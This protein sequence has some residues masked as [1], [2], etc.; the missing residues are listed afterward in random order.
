MALTRQSNMCLRALATTHGPEA[1]VSHR[2]HGRPHQNL[3]ISVF[4][5][6]AGIGS[7][8]AIGIA[9][10]YGLRVDMDALD[11]H[12][13]DCLEKQQAVYAVVAIIG[14]TEESSLDPL[15]PIIELRENTEPKDYPL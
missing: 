14:S 2:T 13:E 6:V 12:L 9:I 4:S 10:D 8:N 15:L 5:A 7:K 3:L 11:K 1:V